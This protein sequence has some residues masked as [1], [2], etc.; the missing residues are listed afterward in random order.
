LDAVVT[1]RSDLFCTVMLVDP[2]DPELL[3]VFGSD[4]LEVTDGVFARAVPSGTE[5]LNT[6]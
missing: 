6:A 1:R 4:V 5:A 3:L 2:A